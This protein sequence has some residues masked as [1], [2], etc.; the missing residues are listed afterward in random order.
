VVED[1]PLLLDLYP[2]YLSHFPNFSVVA[3]MRNGKELVEYLT[4]IQEAENSG[5]NLSWPDLIVT[6]Y[7]MPEM[8]GLE[9]TKLARL[10]KPTLKIVL[11][12]A[13]DL[14]KEDSGYFD[15]TLR[16]PFSA[17]DFAQTIQGLLQ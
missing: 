13:Y 6:D 10:I 2:M 1:D 8:D 12:S 16:K 15:A 11:V 14:P 5:N 4:R 17:E 7:R 9:A 3:K